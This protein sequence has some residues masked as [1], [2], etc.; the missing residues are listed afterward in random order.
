MAQKLCNVMVQRSRNGSTPIDSRVDARAW[1]SDF[2]AT[3]VFGGDLGLLNDES[4]SK[5][6][7]KNKRLAANHLAD[8]KLQMVREDGSDQYCLSVLQ[9]V[10][11][12]YSLL[13]EATDGDQP[14]T[15]GIIFENLQGM[16][17]A[18]LKMLITS[19]GAAAS[20][21]AA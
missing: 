14:P 6:Y 17:R 9:A 21:D 10:A 20:F 12:V 15:S 2:I 3:L 5:L 13:P 11:L 16:S 8:R 19:S 7:V 1:A 18:V 4:R